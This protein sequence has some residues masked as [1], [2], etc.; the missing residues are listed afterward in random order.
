MNLEQVTGLLSAMT[1][2]QIHA[3]K[4]AHGLKASA[5]RKA[6][7]IA[8][9]AARYVASLPAL[10]SAP[11]T[12]AINVYEVL[13]IQPEATVRCNLQQIAAFERRTGKSWLEV[14]IAALRN[15]HHRARDLTVEETWNALREGELWGETL[16]G[17]LIDESFAHDYGTMTESRLRSVVR[18]VGRKLGRKIPLTQG[19]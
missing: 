11:T 9:V 15:V 13:G 16:R 5:P 8:K 19:A 12:K 14:L 4:K 18:K 2:K 3:W 17:V 10:G 6:E 7:L 1:V